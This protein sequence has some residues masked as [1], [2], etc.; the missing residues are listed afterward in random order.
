[1]IDVCFRLVAR[2]YDK[3]A[4]KKYKLKKHEPISKNTLISRNLANTDNNGFMSAYLINIRTAT[5][6]LSKEEQ[7]HQYIDLGSGD[8]RLLGYLSMKYKNLKYIGVEIDNE[9]YMYSQINYSDNKIKFVLNNIFEYHFDFSESTAL[10]L[11][12]SFGDESLRKLLQMIIESKPTENIFLIY[13]NDVHR[14]VLES[15]NFSLL[16]RWQL[17]NLSI[18]RI[19]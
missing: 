6:F 4:S 16:K 8:G 2:L 11:F 13:I 1:M 3:Y 15:M 12:N 17:R 7:V 19:N 10:I 18:W 5:S 14:C 9:L